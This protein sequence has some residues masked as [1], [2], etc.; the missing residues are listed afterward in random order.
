MAEL[1]PAQQLHALLAPTTDEGQRAVK[2]DIV[3]KEQ[4]ERYQKA[5]A[6]EN[7]DQLKLTL[8][9]ITRK[10]TDE[11]RLDKNITSDRVVDTFDFRPYE[12]RTAAPEE[13]PAPEGGDWDK[14]LHPGRSEQSGGVPDYN[15]QKL[16]SKLQGTQKDQVMQELDKILA[17]TTDSA[18]LALKLDAFFH[19]NLTAVGVLGNEY[20]I[21]IAQTQ[22]LYGK[23]DDFNSR[24]DTLQQ[25]ADKALSRLQQTTETGRQLEGGLQEQR[26]EELKN[27]NILRD[28][29]LNKRK[30][31]N[32]VGRIFDDE[33]KRRQEQNDLVGIFREGLKGVG[34]NYY[35][36]AEGYDAIAATTFVTEE[37]PEEEPVPIPQ[38]QPG[39][40]GGPRKKGTQAAQR[41]R[42]AL[43]RG[44][45]LG[46]E[47][48]QAGEA[49]AEAGEALGGAAATA[50]A[51]VEAAGA[52]SLGTVLFW[53]IIILIIV[54]VIAV[55][56]L[57]LSGKFQIAPTG[58]S[59][60]VDNA[61]VISSNLCKTTI[62][63]GVSVEQRCNGSRG[64]L[65][66]NINPGATYP[67]P[68]ATF[69]FLDRSLQNGQFGVQFTQPSGDKYWAYNRPF[70]TGNC[71]PWDYRGWGRYWCTDLVMDSYAAAGFT[72]ILDWTDPDPGYTHNW[73]TGNTSVMIKFFERNSGYAFVPA[74][75]FSPSKVASGSAIFFKWDSDPRF[76]GE[77]TGIVSSIQQD[78]HHS[79]FGVINTIEA[80]AWNKTGHYAYRND[81]PGNQIVGF[82]IKVGGK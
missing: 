1:T 12:T 19:N 22:K 62:V 72:A 69:P 80:N 81:N 43:Q 35:D 52:T 66:D 5:L 45:Q 30:L 44:E 55:A 29:M 61:Q 11:G 48:L 49:G 39:T 26:N 20:K 60:I 32:E 64:D 13:T 59:T 74:N 18:D 28:T 53:V 75:Q 71:F 27:R 4:S 79:G 47:A 2:E 42:Q 78:Q 77:H 68:H 51:E 54:A 17:S 58:S 56:F 15:K 33:W 8:G 65:F 63:S 23:K 46:Q 14:A 34:F 37:V 6:E 82:G 24:T 10:L 25:E 40:T 31:R 38:E 36:Y 70:C 9:D 41:A 67:Q 57:A 21:L 7:P 76:L 16:L 50:G 73:G 3:L